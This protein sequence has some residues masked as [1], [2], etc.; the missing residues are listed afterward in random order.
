MIPS[1]LASAGAANC[2]QLRLVALDAMH[3]A[4]LAIVDAE[5]PQQGQRAEL[6]RR[7]REVERLFRQF[8]S[9]WPEHAGEPSLA[10]PTVSASDNP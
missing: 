1:N 9:R 8:D 7:T 4:V 6:A 5:L 2:A 10:H 3:A